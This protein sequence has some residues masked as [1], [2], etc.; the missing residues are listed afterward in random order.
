MS[1]ARLN[2]GIYRFENYVYVFG[3]HNEEGALK[4]S[5]R[6]S[7]SENKWEPLPDLPEPV[8]QAVVVFNDDHLY[9]HGTSGTVFSFNLVSHEYD[10]P[11]IQFFPLPDKQKLCDEGHIFGFE[12][13]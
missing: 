9:I 8:D 2:A 1:H 5:E 11:D 7:I 3:G 6:Y 12:G 4:E 13:A 10:S